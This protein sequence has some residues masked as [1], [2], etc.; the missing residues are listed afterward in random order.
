MYRFHNNRN[1]E[2]YIKCTC[3][4][5][6]AH[7]RMWREYELKTVVQACGTRLSLNGFRLVQHLC[8]NNYLCRSGPWWSK[9]QK[10]FCVC[11][12]LISLCFSV[13][14]LHPNT[15]LLIDYRCLFLLK[16]QHQNTVVSTILHSELV[17]YGG[18]SCPV[19]TL[20]F[21]LRIPFVNP[22][23]ITSFH[24]SSCGNM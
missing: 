22:N 13:V 14:L 17:W 21:H 4:C 6:C 7:A 12:C 2:I 9:T 19:H 5:V 1:I 20:L 18:F 15:P 16:Y 11:C 23:F 8:T 3:V 10:N 24:F